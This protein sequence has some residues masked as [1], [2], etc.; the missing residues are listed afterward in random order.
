MD[1]ANNSAPL[2]LYP[3]QETGADWLA[4]RPRACLWDEMGLGKTIT[5]IAAVDRVGAQTVLVICPAVVLHNWKR[6]FGRWSS[7]RRVQVITASAQSF[8]ASA[9][10]VVVSEN[11]IARVRTRSQIL[12]RTWSVC[13]VDEA[14]NFRNGTTKRAKTLFALSSTATQPITGCCERVWMLT[15]TP[16][17]NN[18]LELWTMLRGLFPERIRK[19][20]GQPAG[21][22]EFRSRY[23]TTRETMYGTKVTGARNV[24]DL[25]RRLYGFTLR[26]LVKD[27]LPDLPPIRYEHLTVTPKKRSRELIAATDTVL[28]RCALHAAPTQH[29][30]LEVM[31]ASKDPEFATMR[32]LTGLCKVEPAVRL[33]RDELESGALSKVVVFAHHRDVVED[34]RL[35]LEPFGAF[36]IHGGVAVRH[37][38]A[39]ITQFQTDPAVRVAVCQLTAAGV[40]ITLT[41]AHEVVLVESS[42]VPGDNAQAVARCHRIGQTQPVRARFLALANSVDDLLV[43]AIRQK[44]TMISAVLGTASSPATP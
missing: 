15:G 9:S 43:D 8:D 1:N 27:Y 25:R 5:A 6:E 3:Y 35:A 38:D 37:R 13:V 36:A 40:G 12:R 44:T 7:E 30:A 17:P 14:H 16:T 23:C 42:F 29:A 18:P 21:W 31:A 26:R 20:S 11:M 19:P 22:Q 32:R 39:H 28:A 24:D 33:L 2:T 10:V 4:A 41:A 34:L